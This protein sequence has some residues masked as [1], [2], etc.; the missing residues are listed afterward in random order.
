MAAFP[1]TGVRYDWRDLSEATDPVV[2][3]AAMERGIAK[4]RRT[5]SD[6][7]VEIGLTLHFDTKAEAAAFET[8]FFTTVHA[9]QDFF[10]FV[11]PRLGTTVQARVVGGELGALSYL[12][13][14]MAYSR[15]SIK[16]EYWRS[17]W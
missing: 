1:T 14:A 11:H 13:P 15:R 3:R 8:W 10:D 17:T 2:E 6:A 9:G 12:N 4:Q 7:R 5:N 16:L